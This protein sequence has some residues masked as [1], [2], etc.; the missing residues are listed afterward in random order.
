VTVPVLK[1]GEVFEYTSTAPL[2]VRPIGTTIIAARM[3]GEYKYIVLVEA[4]ETATPEQMKTGGDQSDEIVMFH[5]GSTLSFP[6]LNASNPSLAAT[7]KMTKMM[8]MMTT[9][10]TT[11]MMRQWQLLWQSQRRRLLP[12]LRTRRHGKGLPWLIDD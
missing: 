10:T 7:K 5:Q 3:K 12:Q 6:I 2:S 9:T 11:I 4:Q 1:P 8:M